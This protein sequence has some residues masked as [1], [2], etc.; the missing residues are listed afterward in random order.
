MPEG[1]EI[2]RAADDLDRVLARKR[3]LRID[4]RVPR[5]ARQAR[6][7]KGAGINRVYSR[8]KALLIEFDCGLTHYSHNQLFGEWEIT[9]A[10]PAADSRRAVRVVLSTA[11]HT[12]TLYSATEIELLPTRDVER[13]PYIARLGPDALDGTT[14]VSMVRAR[15]LDAA[16]RNRSLAALLLDQHFVAGLGNYLRSDILFA[17]GLPASVRPRDLD[18]ARRARLAREILR[19]TRQAYRAGGVTNDLS[20]ARAARRSGASHEASRFLAYGRAGAPCWTCGTTIQRDDAGGRGLFHCP[21][22]QPPVSYEAPRTR[23]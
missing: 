7:L 12:A 17:A 6:K 15:L 10:P 22:C 5:L 18:D 9:H 8:S 2:R 13:H 14:T 11:T 19:V 20:R 23:R 16:F 1:P 21:V 4:Y 3:L